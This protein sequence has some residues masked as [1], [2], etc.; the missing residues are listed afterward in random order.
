MC[1]RDRV[2]K[3]HS[4]VLQAE[5]PLLHQLFQHLGGELRPGVLVESLGKVAVASLVGF[6]LFHKA[7]QGLHL[8]GPVSY[9][10]LDVYKRQPKIFTTTKTLVRSKSS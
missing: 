9:T 4:L 5:P 3:A 7:H 2:H 6:Y 10:H 8:L 1:I